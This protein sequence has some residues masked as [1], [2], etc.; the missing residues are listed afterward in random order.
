MFSKPGRIWDAGRGL[1]ITAQQAGGRLGWDHSSRGGIW[2]LNVE[3]MTQELPRTQRS[4]LPSLSTVFFWLLWLS[5]PAPRVIFSQL[6]AFQTLPT[7]TMKENH[8]SSSLSSCG[9][10]LS[11]PALPGQ[12]FP[13]QI[14]PHP[15]S[16]TGLCS[17]SPVL[18]VRGG[19]SCCHCPSL[20]PGAP[21]DRAGVELP[22]APVRG[23]SHQSWDKQEGHS[24]SCTLFNPKGEAT[25]SPLCTTALGAA[26]GFPRGME[27]F[28]P[29]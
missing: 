10:R 20:S 14:Q 27:I 16:S 21:G 23:K 11:A 2:S 5:F 24:Q 28:F 4:P 1:G 25:A 8:R 13:P 3:L 18:A 9:L 7:F 22:P 12:F 15:P 17:V 6:I 19:P 29:G 26:G